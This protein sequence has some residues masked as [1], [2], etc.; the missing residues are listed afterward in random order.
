MVA[1]RHRTFVWLIYFR[2]GEPLAR[3]TLK[4]QTVGLGVSSAQNTRRRVQTVSAAGIQDVRLHANKLLNLTE[5]H[6]Y[7]L[8]RFIHASR[9]LVPTRL[10]STQ[11]L[12]MRMMR[13]ESVQCSG[14][15]LG[16]VEEDSSGENIRCFRGRQAASEGSFAL[17][18]MRFDRCDQSVTAKL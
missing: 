13:Q 12:T 9:G 1:L 6:V 17:E 2:S 4:L 8:F 3:Q 18:L 16:V 15:T 7:P 10:K 5:G 11:D 14:N